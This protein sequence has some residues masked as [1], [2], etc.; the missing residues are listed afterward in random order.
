MIVGDLNVAPT[1]LD[2][3]PGKDIMLS[4]SCTTT[5]RKGFA[6]LLN[7]GFLDIYRELHRDVRAYTWWYATIGGKDN[8]NFPGLGRRIDFFLLPKECMKWVIRCDIMRQVKGAD[9]CPVELEI[10]L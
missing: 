10:D 8:Y 7:L 2:T 9:H 1:E 6:E 3:H 5:E 4:P